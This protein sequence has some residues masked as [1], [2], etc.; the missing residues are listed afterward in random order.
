MSVCLPV[1]LSCPGLLNAK[2]QLPF[3]S[4]YTCLP[5]SSIPSPPPPHPPATCTQSGAWGA[6]HCVASAAYP[7]QPHAQ[8]CSSARRRPAKR[9]VAKTPEALNIFSLSLPSRQSR[10][11]RYMQRSLSQSISRSITRHYSCCIL[12]LLVPGECYLAYNRSH[13]GSKRWQIALRQSG[14]TELQFRNRS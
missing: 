5:L 7:P 1:A 14:K 8:C 4:A 13:T 3:C 9:C 12:I 10:G 2:R 11:C 6:P